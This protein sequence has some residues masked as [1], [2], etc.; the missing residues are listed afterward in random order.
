MGWGDCAAADPASFGCRSCRVPMCGFHA[1]CMLVC[2][3]SFGSKA[4][5]G[6]MVALHRRHTHS[7]DHV[8]VGRSSV[9]AHCMCLSGSSRQAVE[10]VGAP[11]SARKRRWQ[12]SGTVSAGGGGG[13]GPAVLIALSAV[14]TGVATECWTHGPEVVSQLSRTRGVCMLGNGVAGCV[15]GSGPRT[16]GG[17]DDCN[18][19][20]GRVAQGQW[21]LDQWGKGIL[22]MLLCLPLVLKGWCAAATLGLWGLRLAAAL[23]GC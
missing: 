8:F 11:G 5:P 22:C 9:G 12:Q 19:A 17:A 2:A 3:A 20:M 15:L 18:L 6:V 21:Q 1:V 14:G 4:W 7:G 13:C 10:E 16:R 23:G